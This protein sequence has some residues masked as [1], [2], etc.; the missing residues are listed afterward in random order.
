MKTTER[1]AKE[2]MEAHCRRHGVEPNWD[3][4]KAHGRLYWTTKASKQ[5]L[6]RRRK[7]KP[8]RP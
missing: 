4:L 7:L 2:L 1:H 5:E 6:A 8:T 3:A